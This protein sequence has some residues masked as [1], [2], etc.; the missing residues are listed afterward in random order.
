M[1]SSI[2][3]EESEFAP[4]TLTHL[5]ECSEVSV[6]APGYIQPNGVL[7]A[8]AQ[9]QTWQPHL[10][11][12]DAQM[13]EMNGYEATRQIRLQETA[14]P[15]LPTP[16]IALT[17]Y[18]FESDRQASFHA[19][20]NEH[21]VKPFNETV[22]FE[23]IAR[24]LGVRYCYSDKLQDPLPQRT[25]TPQDLQSMPV[26]WLAQVHEAALDLQDERLY[27]LMAQIP[28]SDQWLIQAM[29]SLVERLQFEAIANLTQLQEG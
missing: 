16:I 23:T 22:L 18:V 11:L 29:T 5:E 14:E 9:W 28:D 25:I 4:S 2:A 3:S 6:Y 19:G 12:M 26:V 20:C 13:P 24:Y 27:Q 10:I 21:I 1:N 17:A 8:I 15:R 7:V